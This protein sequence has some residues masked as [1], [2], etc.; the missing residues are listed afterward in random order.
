MSSQPTTFEELLADLSQHGV[1][2][3]LV[4]GLTVAL[5]GFVRTTLDVAILVQADEENILRLLE[6]L[7]H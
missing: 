2:Y 1:K 7:E 5:C 3:L 6:R 4:G